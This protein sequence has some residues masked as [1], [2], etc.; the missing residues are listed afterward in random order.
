MTGARVAI[1][2]TPTIYKSFI[3]KYSALSGLSPNLL[4]HSHRYR[5][6]I[7]GQPFR[8]QG[9]VFHFTYTLHTIPCISFKVEWRGRSIVFTGDHMNI[10]E[11]IS[12]L[13]EK[14]SLHKDER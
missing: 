3:R 2:T 6:A 8:F 5:P 12:T 7:I 11:Q 13:E 1:I 10:P 4:R 14:V 9:A